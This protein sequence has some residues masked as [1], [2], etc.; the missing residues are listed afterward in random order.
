MEKKVYRYRQRERKKERE[1]ERERASERE[2]IK[3]GEI[4]RERGRVRYRKSLKG[5]I[6]KRICSN[7][8]NKK[9][10]QM[11]RISCRNGINVSHQLIISVTII[12]TSTNL[13]IETEHNETENYETEYYCDW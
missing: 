11:I 10:W 4:G 1:K 7:Q 13:K 3:E 12:F 9:I 6:E 5:R 2:S 8:N